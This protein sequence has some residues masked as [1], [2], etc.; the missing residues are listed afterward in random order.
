MDDGP[1]SEQ[2]D[3]NK[4]LVSHEGIGEQL[5]Y[6]FKEQNKAERMSLISHG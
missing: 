5:I 1:E 6:S 2:E 4:S 3:N